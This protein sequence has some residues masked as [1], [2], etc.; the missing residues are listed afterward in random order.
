MSRAGVL[1]LP[2]FL[3]AVVSPSSIAQKA[4]D[5][6]ANEL[7]VQTALQQGRTFLNKGQ[8]RQAVEVLEQHLPFIN[9]KVDYLGV[10]RD[11]YHAYIRELQINKQDALIPAVE[12]KLHVLESGL[13]SE[14]KVDQSALPPPDPP[15]SKSSVKVDPFQ[16]TPLM[17][18]DNPRELAKRGDAAFA[19]RNYAEANSY[20]AKAHALDPT[21][22]GPRVMDWAY[23]RIV[24]VV[25]RLNNEKTE[26]SATLAGMDREITE[27][28]AL[29]SSNPDL[30]N[31]CRTVQARIRERMGLQFVSTTE[32]ST[33]W[34][35]TESTNF[36]LLHHLSQD[37]AQQLLPAFEKAR[38]A[39]FQKWIAAVGT[40][41]W[42]VRCDVYLHSTAAD[43][44]KATS[45]DARWLGR[46]TFEMIDRRMTR[47]R[48]DLIADNPEMLTATMPR[49]V[50]HAVLVDVF[51]DPMLP[52]W[53]EFA[54]ALLAEPRENVQRYLQAL[55]KLAYD[56]KLLAMGQLVMLKDYP[57]QTSITAF[58]VQSVSLVDMLVAERGAQNFT[59][60]LQSAQRYGF[61]KALKDSYGIK[62]FAA[63]QDH[64]KKKA[65]AGQ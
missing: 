25:N 61:E 7:A 22:L 44:T 27:S 17:N 64:W 54:M 57:D 13:N 38:N 55:P 62:N 11:A 41:T 31:Y 33:G 30:V 63:L 14:Q 37:R 60:F 19:Q 18:D 5:P 8:P 45:A 48:I 36:R 4:N 20:F 26:D 50:T 3:L 6:I 15:P 59:L 40:N 46:T 2:I 12:A 23:C 10:L 65:F 43:Y 21:V 24:P 56:H 39:A 53:A 16:Q 9:G 32:D 58:Y 34:L 1:L 51:P 28:M 35:V 52:R 47:R 42:P 49:E 29:A